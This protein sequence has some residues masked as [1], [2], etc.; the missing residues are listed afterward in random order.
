MPKRRSGFIRAEALHALAPGHALE[1]RFNLNPST[2]LNTC[3]RKPLANLQHI[4]F[5]DKAHLQ[6]DLSKPRLTVRTQILVTEAARN[7]T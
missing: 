3:L 1:G 2:S 5:V 4:V 6:V 7:W